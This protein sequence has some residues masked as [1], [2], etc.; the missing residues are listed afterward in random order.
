M[1]DED[2][3]Q[4]QVET[5]AAPP[6]S[7]S[8]LAVQ[9]RAKASKPAAAPPP[10]RGDDLMV[11][12][13]AEHSL[14]DDET[15]LIKRFK[16]S[17]ELI[18]A[19]MQQDPAYGEAVM[20]RLQNHEGEK[21]VQAMMDEGDEIKIEFL[22]AED[23]KRFTS[24][25]AANASFFNT[26]TFGQLSRIMGGAGALIEGRPYEEVVEE[27]AEK[28][29]LLSKA[30]PKSNMAGTAVGFLLPGS[31]VK[32]L[33]E[34]AAGFG[35]KGA[36]ALLSRISQNPNLLQKV[37]QSAAGG[38]AGAGSVG[39]VQ[40][41][42]GSDLQGLSFDRGAETALAAAEGGAL[43]GAALPVASA[44]LS[45]G[46]RA[47]AP[48]V[49]AVARKVSDTV[50]RGVEQLSGTSVE[51]LRAYNKN[52]QA[53]REAAGSEAE[54]GRELVSF[55]QNA[56]KSQ[57]PE[58]KLARELLPTMPHVD[59]SKLIA[60]MRTKPANLRPDQVPAWEELS[61][62]WAEWVEKQIT[63]KGGSVKKVPGLVMREI[64][65]DLQSVGFDRNN[66]ALNVLL[67]QAQSVGNDAIKTM[68]AGA[69]KVGETYLGL[70]G[71]AAEKQGILKFLRGQMGIPKRGV[72]DPAVVEGKAQSFVTRLFGKSNEVRLARMRDL[73]AKFGTN[74]VENA[75]NARYAAELGPKGK[76]ST[77]SN[78]STGKAV[79][80]SV[81]GGAVGGPVGAVAGAV[82]SSPRAGAAIIGA[83]DKITG[84]IRRM[85]ANPEALARLGKSGAT[86]LAVRR[87]A[88]EISK[89]IVKDGPIS[90]AGV[91]RLVADTP[92]FVGLVHAFDL[93]ERS[94]ETG[95]AKRAVVR[96]QGADASQIAT[97]QTV[98]SGGQPQ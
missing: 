47:A 92:F 40:G 23:P 98:P 77:F 73:D 6:P 67:R 22:K 50:A 21:L 95:T 69:G 90:A 59:G 74:F 25:E 36:G 61:G 84:F 10:V 68:A 49:K 12:A 79:M 86:P 56:K 16:L 13:Q 18:D 24:A 78:L 5:P 28:L 57:L 37:V 38:A 9:T 7:L 63:L 52:P 3:I 34:K 15:Q 8:Q 81:T 39:M 54:V 4:P 72:P 76:P 85:V 91:T 43:L 14:N 65:D 80:G 1:A 2:I 70:M 41:T 87:I 93:A 55:L 33:F 20:G 30:F 89:T 51:A 60:F 46:A 19:K 35:A 83:S 45:A 29:R 62:K 96:M 97:P 32:A 48:A 26:V 82:A 64:V 44:G 42:L 17:K 75:Q 66:P 31:P 71:K 53:L 88:D 94:Q 11:R 58:S 27:Q